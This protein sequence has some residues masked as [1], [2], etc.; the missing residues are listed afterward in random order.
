MILI[1]L[2][3]AREAHAPTGDQARK[4]FREWLSPPDPTI[5]Y[6]TARKAYHDGTATWFTRSV[7]FEQWK[8]SGSERF[9]WIHDKRMFLIL[10]LPWLLLI[11]PVWIDSGLWENYPKVFRYPARYIHGNSY[12]HQVR[13]SSTTRSVFSAPDRK[14]VV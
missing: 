8:E 14:S 6:N 2:S 13:Q 12:L 9:L 5:N 1:H 4:G 3:P 11:L 7:I 10:F